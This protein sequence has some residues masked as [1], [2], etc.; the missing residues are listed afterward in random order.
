MNI[1]ACFDS[2]KRNYLWPKDIREEEMISEGQKQ[3]LTNLIY[4]NIQDSSEAEM[5][6]SQLENLSYVEAE[7]YILDFSFARWK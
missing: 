7:N 4:S 1:I 5:R 2:P 6:C 3:K